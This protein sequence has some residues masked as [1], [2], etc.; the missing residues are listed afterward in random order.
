[1]KSSVVKWTLIASLATS[2]FGMGVTA[3]HA[4]LETAQAVTTV[5]SMTSGVNV[6]SGPGTN[7]RVLGQLTFNDPLTVVRKYN[8]DWY[9]V[10][11]KANNAFVSASWVNSKPNVQAYYRVITNGDQL[12][13]RGGPGLKYRVLWKYK[14][15]AIVPMLNRTNSSWYRVWKGGSTLGYVSTAYIKRLDE[16]IVITEGMKLNLR[17]GPGS[18]YKVV[19]K[20]ERGTMVYVVHKNH[21]RW[22]A[23]AYDNGK[24]GYV[25]AKYLE[26]YPY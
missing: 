20:I 23:I 6:R 7:Y 14:N 4:Q 11:Y 15:G 8:S 13:A 16:Y 5:F 26:K 3:P 25:N 21:P 12:N 2:A 24:V 18:K 17:T 9:E 19:K 10:Y 22:T 1:M